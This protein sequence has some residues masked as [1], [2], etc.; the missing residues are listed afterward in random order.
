MKQHPGQKFQHCQSVKVWTMNEI[1]Y[2]TS[3]HGSHV[4]DLTP[5][6]GFGQVEIP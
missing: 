2:H 6:T 3:L 5:E 1:L 4:L